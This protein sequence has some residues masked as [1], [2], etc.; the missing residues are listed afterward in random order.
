MT[1]ARLQGG[2][3]ELTTKSHW[4][5]AWATPPRWRLPSPLIVGTRNVQ[6]ILRADVRP[7]MRVLELGCAPGKILAWVASALRAEV[8]GLDYSDRGIGWTKELFR[9]LSLRLDLRCEDAFKTTFPAASFDVVY[10]FGLIEHFQDPRAIVRAHVAL[11][12]PGGKSIIAVPNYGGLYGRLQRWLDPENLSIHNLEIMNIRALGLLAPPELTSH[13][14]AYATG[15]LSPW[16]LSFERKLPRHLALALAYG[17]NGISLAQP[18]DV[19]PL[20]PLLVLEITRRD[21]APC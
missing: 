7:G 21:D 10:S 4:D 18:V 6:R 8:S 20:C 14:R 17:L 13:V 1:D 19:R 3:G 9:A 16:L 12:R 15:R 11:A 5:S 2:T